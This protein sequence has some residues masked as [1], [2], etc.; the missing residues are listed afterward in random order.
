MNYLETHN[1]TVLGLRFRVDPETDLRVAAELRRRA[2]DLEKSANAD[3]A[4]KVP[5][6]ERIAQAM[7]LVTT[8]TIGYNE[9]EQARIIRRMASTGECLWHALWV[10]FGSRDGSGCDCANCGKPRRERRRAIDS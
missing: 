8:R 1:P 4:G 3:D 9:W 7:L 2:D 6:D 10:L 5:S